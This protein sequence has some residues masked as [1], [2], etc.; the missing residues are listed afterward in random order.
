MEACPTFLT[1]TANAALVERFPI[2]RCT[3]G[4]I[5]SVVRKIKRNKKYY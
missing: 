5:V 1:I 3:H 4:L 2:Y